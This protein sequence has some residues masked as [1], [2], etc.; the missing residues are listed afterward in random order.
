MLSRNNKQFVVFAGIAGSLAI[1]MVFGACCWSQRVDHKRLSQ[2]EEMEEEIAKEWNDLKVI[3]YSLAQFSLSSRFKHILN[4]GTDD[5]F[6]AMIRD[7]ES[8]LIRLAGYRCVQ[9]RYPAR[10]YEAAISTILSA[11]LAGTGLFASVL[12]DIKDTKDFKT[13]RPVLNSLIA[14][15][16][17]GDPKV[18]DIV[19][20]LVDMIPVEVA[21]D[22]HSESGAKMRQPI[23]G[24][25]LRRVF[26]AGGTPTDLMKKQLEQC[27]RQSGWARVVYLICAGANEPEYLRRF[28]E[29]LSDDTIHDFYVV[30][31]V[32]LQSDFVAKNIDLDALDIPEKRKHLIRRIM[33]TSEERFRENKNATKQLQP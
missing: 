30:E 28:R 12:Q 23:L 14:V 7:G 1:L 31:L 22:W 24:C 8:D 29:C 3:D 19:P 18:D 33:K 17:V 2:W 10:A 27:G 15:I 16:P 5:D 6:F 25:V 4:H 9:E 26:R 20:L 11:K 13:T 32:A 21:E